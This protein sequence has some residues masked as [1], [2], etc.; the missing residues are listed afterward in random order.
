MKLGISHAELLGWGEDQVELMLAY[1]T[2]MN[3]I[4]PNG[5]RMSEATSPKAALEYYGEDR[6]RYAVTGP[7]TNHAEK[8]RLDAIA[9]YQ[10]SAGD[11]N[12]NGMFWSVDKVD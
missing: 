9:A 8:M 5:E 1:Q 2:F 3:G 7:H 6:I 10:K 4:G 12:T 11:E